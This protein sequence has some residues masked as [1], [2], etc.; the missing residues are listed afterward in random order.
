MVEGILF[1][2]GLLQGF[3]CFEVKIKCLSHQK[4][5]RCS[6]SPV[7]VPCVEKLAAIC[8]DNETSSRCHGKVCQGGNGSNSSGDNVEVSLS[9]GDFKRL[10]Q[11]EQSRQKQA[12]KGNPQACLAGG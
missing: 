5:E 3:V 10:G 7:N 4:H 1:F 12:S 8:T 11:E 9:I 6:E 2:F